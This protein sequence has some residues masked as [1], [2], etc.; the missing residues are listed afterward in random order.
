[1]RHFEKIYQI[2]AD[3]HG[4][5]AELESKLSKPKPIAELVAM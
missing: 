3:R 5:P 2:S 1:M 4:G